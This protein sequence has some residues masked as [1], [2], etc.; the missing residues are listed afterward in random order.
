MNIPNAY[1]LAISCISLAGCHA[2]SNRTPD[3]RVS[4]QDEW[5]VPFKSTSLS[6]SNFEEFDRLVKDIGTAR[7]VV[8]G[9]THEDGAAY[10]TKARVVRFLHERMGFNVIVWEMPIFQASLVERELDSGGD[11]TAVFQRMQYP[12]N[13]S[14]VE[15]LFEY[16]A[17]SKRTGK[18]LFF[19]GC[20]CKFGV[21]AN[22][23]KH[24]LL[25]FLDDFFQIGPDSIA[26]PRVWSPLVKWLV[27]PPRVSF[28]SPLEVAPIPPSVR[29]YIAASLDK[30]SPPGESMT[31]ADAIESLLITLNANKPQLLNSKGC[32][33]VDIVERLLLSARLAERWHNAPLIHGEEGDRNSHL[34][35]ERAMAE[36]I[37]WLARK[38]YPKEKLIIWTGG[39][40]AF[41][42]INN[43]P[44]NSGSANHVDQ[45]SNPF[46]ECASDVL[47]SLFGNDVYVVGFTGHHGAVGRAESAK[48]PP[49]EL[50]TV[51]GD[52]I[53]Q[54]IYESGVA[55]AFVPLR[56]LPRNHWLRTPQISCVY[57]GM[58]IRSVWPLSLDCIFYYVERR[59]SHGV[60]PNER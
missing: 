23:L 54:R 39:V 19:A 30:E 29:R 34:Y 40:H 50:P 3:S 57:N 10:E 36:S 38:S 32:E 17:Q 49:W 2:T 26:D 28:N 44:E 13:R 33:Q 51:P 43:P 48:F 25:S 58:A 35:R 22:D 11:A 37:L 5:M 21:V 31:V 47:Y 9:E 56:L 55:S 18:P 42:Y 7:I 52:S 16:V 59:P 60:E 8:L 1:L 53:E 45:S 41:K 20:D 12:W 46:P 27:S 6:D 24:E 14:E 15:E 4:P